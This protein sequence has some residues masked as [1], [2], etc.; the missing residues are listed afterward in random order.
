MASEA[1]IIH[2]AR[3]KSRRSAVEEAV[4]NVG[5]PATV[6]DAVDG[7]KLSDEELA[8]CYSSRPLFQPHYP[9]LLGRGEIACFQS[10]RSAWRAIV[11]KELDFGVVLE[12][13]VEIDRENLSKAVCCFKEKNNMNLYISLQTRPLRSS[14][15]VVYE[16][17]GCELI[18]VTPIPL[19]TSGQIVGREAAIRLLAISEK[20]DRPVDCFLQLNWIT[21]VRVLCANPSGIAQWSENIPES[22]AQA[23]EKKSILEKI[24]RELFRTIYRALI[25][26]RSK[27]NKTS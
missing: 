3:A 12:D 1:F 16:N 7:Q 18:E 27:I 21:S 22:F 20:I 25:N 6:L 10:H 24:K 26:L 14:G 19:R 2:L 23:A 8:A 9:F 13:D 5:M 4:L 11:E 17:A 15:Q